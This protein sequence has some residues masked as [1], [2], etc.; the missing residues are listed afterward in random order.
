MIIGNSI[1][2]TLN[3]IP[4]G[5]VFTIADFG[6]EKEKHPTLVKALS[7]LVSNGSI[8]RIAKGKYYKPKQTMFGELKPV[9]NELVK[10]LLERNG[11][12]LGYITGTAAFAQM[13]LTTQISSNITIGTNKYRRPLKRGEYKVT[14]LLQPNIITENNIPFLRILDAL[15]LIKQIPA[16]TPDDVVRT[17]S[18][19]IKTLSS[20]QQQELTSLAMLYAPFVRSQVGAILENIGVEESSLRNSLSG[21]T[22]YKLPISSNA[23]PTKSKWN[24]V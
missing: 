17:I 16:T 10:D 22:T 18:E 24:I 8:K 19:K 3:T 21:V 11:Q 2:E 12:L 6:I 13:G 1:K 7:R 9:A 4:Q 20:D 23:L 14:F 5:K 15:K